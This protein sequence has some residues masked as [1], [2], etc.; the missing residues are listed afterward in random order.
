M[1]KQKRGGS[2]SRSGGASEHDQQDDQL[3]DDHRQS[4]ELA[5]AVAGQDAPAFRHRQE[6]DGRAAERQYR[7][8]QH[9][10]AIQLAP[11]PRRACV[12]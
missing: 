1:R 9:H 6:G 7:E 3:T 12:R 11:D 4:D 2:S 8:E 5:W 10:K